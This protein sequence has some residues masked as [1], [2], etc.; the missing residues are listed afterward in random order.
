MRYLTI[1]L[2]MLAISGPHLW[3][4]DV[5]LINAVPYAGSQ[6]QGGTIEYPDGQLT[7]YGNAWKAVALPESYTVG[8]TTQ[9]RF[10]YDPTDAGEITGIAL[11]NNLGSLN[12]STTFQL[13]GSQAQWGITGYETAVAGTYIIPIGEHYTGTFT[14]LALVCD[15][16]ADA[17]GTVLFDNVSIT[18]WPPVLPVFLVAETSDILVAKENSVLDTMTSAIVGKI[19]AYTGYALDADDGFVLD[20]ALGDSLASA[21]SNYDNLANVH[22]AFSWTN[23]NIVGRDALQALA[24]ALIAAE[25]AGLGTYDGAAA[26]GSLQSALNIMNALYIIENNG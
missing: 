17:S 24:D 20:T 10:H 19:Q 6:D 1:T 12:Q 22:P 8:A 26:A 15:D 16:D 2:L 5:P 18:D 3:A 25:D 13:G 11:V 7:V 4:L 9:L 14:H 23:V 21:I